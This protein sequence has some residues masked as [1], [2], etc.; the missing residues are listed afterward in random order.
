MKF[1]RHI[2]LA[3]SIASLSLLVACGG[4]SSNSG[5]GSP[6]IQF[7][8]ANPPNGQ[9][10][11]PY[12][13]NSGFS[14]T[15]TGGQGTISFTLNSGNLPTGLTLSSSGALTGTP[16]TAQTAS[17][18]ILAT[19]SESPAKTQ[20]ST[21]YTVQ[22]TQTGFMNSSL[23]GNYTFLALGTDALGGL[24]YQVAGVMVADGNGNITGGEET[25]QDLNMPAFIPGITGTYTV[26]SNGMVSFTINTGLNNVGNAGVETFSAV[27][28]SSSKGL[29][30][31]FDNTATSSGT[32]DQQ[33]ANPAMLSGGYA[34]SVFGSDLFSSF[35]SL[36]GVFNVDNN[37]SAGTISG[38]GS[39][40]DLDYSGSLSL[41][42]SLTGSVTAPDMFGRVSI[43]LNLG[44]P[45]TIA[46][47]GYIL[48]S[49]QIRLIENDAFGISGGTAISQ[50]SSTGTFTANSAFSGTFAYAFSGFNVAGAG[51]DAGV[52]T[53]DGMGSL[54]NGL[55]DQ[56]QG[57]GVISD[58]LTGAYV[59]DNTGTGRVAAGTNFGTNGSGPSLIFYLTGNG[60][61][62]PMIQV[63][64]FA[65]AAGT[66]YVQ[67]TANPSF[68]GTYG[69]GF[70]SFDT[71]GDE[72]DGVAQITANSSAGTFSGTANINE[73][74]TPAPNQTFNG[75]FSS[76]GSG[77][78]T[79]TITTNGGTPISVAFY[80]IDSTQAFAIETDANAISLGVL[81]QQVIP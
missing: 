29:I 44:T 71:L 48:D 55:I 50:G 49:T 20:V 46:F 30:I 26:S 9:T 63:D 15:A 64:T 57:G 76:S 53:A 6:A 60:N 33:T 8:N 79:G 32:L 3:L 58:T 41:A 81:R 21:T 7:T 19:D 75:T 31:Q 27:L 61:P 52:I 39:V 25:Y 36:G 67:T 14:F 37:P 78:F 10:S 1:T 65:Y 35:L 24:P 40:A 54:T 12:G 77:S 38:A 70:T 2:L 69:F 13:G 17:F 72:S 16:T 47:D 42:Q 68:N 4:G 73:A 62:V 11:T 74:L 59:V 18:T 45:G 51:A 28:L 80:F 66:A 56:N 23:T 5:G 22:I 34:F 43:T